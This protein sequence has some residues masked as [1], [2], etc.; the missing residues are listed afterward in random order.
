MRMRMCTTWIRPTPNS[1]A[2]LMKILRH[3]KKMK[4]YHR[5]RRGKK[6][7]HL[8]RRNWWKKLTLLAIMM[9][10]IVKIQSLRKQMNPLKANQWKIFTAQ[11]PI[12]PYFLAVPQKKQRN[13]KTSYYR[14]R[15]MSQRQK[16]HLKK[17][18]LEEEYQ[19]RSTSQH[20]TVAKMT[21]GQMR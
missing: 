6:H 9:M 5:K 2:K 7:I 14:L 8:Q 19:R 20:K 12:K 21:R 4:P 13:C 17:P 10:M 16:Y 18:G 11:N 3:S 1:V 15:L